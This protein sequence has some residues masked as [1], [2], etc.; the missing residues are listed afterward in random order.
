MELI[1]LN[2]ENGIRFSK[3]FNSVYLAEKFINKAKRSKKIQIV[4]KFY[5]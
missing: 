1:I 5:L 2:L 3:I 4:G